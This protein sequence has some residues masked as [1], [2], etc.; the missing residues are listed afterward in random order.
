MAS[1]AARVDWRTA[2]DWPFAAD[3]SVRLP[4]LTGWAI[5]VSARTG[6]CFTRQPS[7]DRCVAIRDAIAGQLAERGLLPR[8]RF[9]RSNGSYAL[10][11]DR[12]GEHALQ[13]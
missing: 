4:K 6:Q 10:H 12:A 3:G 7:M 11:L 8:I 5:S 2:A 13:R 1:A 9:C